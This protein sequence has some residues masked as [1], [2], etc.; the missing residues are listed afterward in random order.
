VARRDFEGGGCLLARQDGRNG[1]D[2]LVR[3]LDVFGVAFSSRIRNC[4]YNTIIR[5]RGSLHF[6]VDDPVQILLALL[7]AS[8]PAAHGSEQA[9]A[10]FEVILGAFGGFFALLVFDLGLFGCCGFVV[11]RVQALHC[12]VPEFL[13]LALGLLFEGAGEGDGV[14]GVACIKEEFFF[15]GLDVIS[16]DHSH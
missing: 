6:S 3:F 1:E 2:L 16:C 14:F 12:A 8:G 5:R 13:R 11:A 9:R 4:S 10:P 7:R 15:A